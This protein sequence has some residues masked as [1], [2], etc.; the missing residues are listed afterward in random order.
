MKLTLCLLR[1]VI[2][3]RLVD[4]PRQP[5]I[6]EIIAHDEA[7]LAKLNI[8]REYH[9]ARDDKEYLGELDIFINGIRQDDEL[10]KK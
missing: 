3:A 2:V 1:V 10:M 5:T 6:N 8:L 4:E 9:E 7:M